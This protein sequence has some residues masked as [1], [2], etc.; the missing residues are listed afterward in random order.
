MQHRRG[1]VA[2]REERLR[3]E[4]VG[5]EPTCDRSLTLW[6][7][8]IACQVRSIR[9][10]SGR[11]GAAGVRPRREVGDTERLACLVIRNGVDLPPG[12]RAACDTGE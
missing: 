6:Q 10:L 8:G 2:E 9:A 3:L 7:F 4:G 5:V 12:E 1:R 11:K